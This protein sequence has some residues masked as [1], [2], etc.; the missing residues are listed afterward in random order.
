MTSDLALLIFMILLFTYT[1]IR[2]W[3]NDDPK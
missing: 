3:K 2:L 1:A